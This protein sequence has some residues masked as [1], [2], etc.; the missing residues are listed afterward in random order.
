MVTTLQILG[1]LG[2]FLYGM[3]V[4]SEG[5]QKFAGAQMRRVLS[6]VT[7]NRVSGMLAGL[8]TTVL[9]Q[10]SS[11]TT[12]LVI[13][14][15]NAGLLTLMQSI[16]VIM[17]ANLGTTFTAWIVAMVGKFSLAKIAVPVIG[18]GFPLFFIGKER[19]RFFGEF[20]IGFGILFL[21]LNFL[22]DSVPDLHLMIQEDPLM[23]A[24]IEGVISMLDGHGYSSYLLFLV[25]GI[26]LTM[27]VQ[28][29]SAAMAITITCA[30]N[31][32]FG[33][34][35]LQVFRISAAVVLG[36][37]IG[38]T[39][40]AWLASLG[41][42]TS[43]KRA[44]RAHFLFNV[45]GVVWMLAVFLVFT[46]AVW[47][48]TGYLPEGLK[49]AKGGFQQSEVAFATAIFHTAFNL[50]NVLILLW[51][52][53][54]IAR[55]VE[56]WV[57]PSGE[58]EGIHQRLKY[59][60]QRLVDTGEL[61]LAEAEGAMRLISKNCVEMFQGFEEVFASPGQDM[62]EKVKH[63]KDMETEADIMAHDITEY[64]VFCSSHEAGKKNVVNIAAMIR[65]VTEIEE[66]TD[67]IYRLVKLVQ[68][69]YN[70]KREFSEDQMK[71]VQE[72]AALVGQALISCDKFLLREIPADVLR[73]VKTLEDRTDTLRKQYNKEA[74][75]RMA[76]G[77]VRVEV[78]NTDINNH[79]EAIANH[80]LNILEEGFS[81]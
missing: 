81:G 26:V 37:N 22:K 40:T 47:T 38:T 42:N 24:R 10:S 78:L 9:V 12:V 2:I 74:M 41:A 23:A 52:V 73:E 15:V 67:R 30:I 76:A 59:I 65:I 5:V 70:K 33:D 49:S 36:E 80:A 79:L 58:D 55:L 39:V 75:G 53:P 11:A 64:L 19:A 32:W 14:L 28:S 62:S 27:I 17:G 48:A 20:L 29:S 34:D 4:L 1:S 6:S 63:L 21:G 8:F 60:S 3:K 25:A 31:G 7:N 18:I 66:C 35:P 77:D 69:K 44:A 71:K 68:R 43:A 50:V 45:L 16:G 56:R 46:N 61:N 51:F 54:Q 13:S 57:K 72:L